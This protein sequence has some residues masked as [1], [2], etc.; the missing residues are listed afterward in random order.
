MHVPAEIWW[1]AGL[2]ALLVAVAVT[3][4]ARG[5]VNAR[6]WASP[7][8]NSPSRLVRICGD[9]HFTWFGV[10]L[11]CGALHGL[12][13]SAGFGL[14][15]VVILELA[16]GYGL[17]WGIAASALESW[18]ISRQSGQWPVKSWAGRW[19]LEAVVAAGA[20]AIVGL[21]FDWWLG[22]GAQA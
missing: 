5:V 12:N 7:T 8:A 2:G 11:L 22:L 20:L 18:R 9:S 14:S 19:A 4:A 13:V 17:I 10:L 3:W 16:A 1:A 6:G 15:S 21:F